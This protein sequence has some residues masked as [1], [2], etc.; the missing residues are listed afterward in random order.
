M[1][2]SGIT[3]SKLSLNAV[4]HLYTGIGCYCPLYH[5]SQVLDFLLHFTQG[6]R[7]EVNNGL[8]Y[9]EQLGDRALKYV[10]VTVP[11]HQYL[12]N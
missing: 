11:I 12:K 7:V 4:F 3:V 1:L 8:S 2:S 6:T 5:F 9:P 10:E